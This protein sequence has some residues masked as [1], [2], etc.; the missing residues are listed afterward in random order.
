VGLGQLAEADPVDPFAELYL[1]VFAI[2]EIALEH[3]VAVVPAYPLAGT[4]I[5]FDGGRRLPSPRAALACLA[6][7][8]AGKP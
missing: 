8:A 5:R 4:P 2:A 1:G 6:R 7:L 3:A